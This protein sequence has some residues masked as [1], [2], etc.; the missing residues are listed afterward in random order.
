MLTQAT[1]ADRDRARNVLRPFNPEISPKPKK[2]AASRP[3]LTN[4][5]RPGRLIKLIPTISNLLF[6]HTPITTRKKNAT[7][8]AVSG[9][10][11][12]AIIK[13]EALLPTALT[14]TALTV[15]PALAQAIWQTCSEP[16]AISCTTILPT[17]P[18]IAT[19]R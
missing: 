19:A 4:I 7:E 12:I 10:E 5:S 9:R 14:L 18:F 1:L 13:T 6:P 15:M 8:T 11:I 3:I 2:F 16:A 17:P